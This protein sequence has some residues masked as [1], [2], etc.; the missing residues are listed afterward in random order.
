LLLP[1]QDPDVEEAHRDRQRQDEPRCCRRKPELP[2]ADPQP[3]DVGPDQV[4][5]AGHAAGVLQHEN[6]GEDPEIPDDL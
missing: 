2:L 5:V 4:G 3:V 1:E 6:L